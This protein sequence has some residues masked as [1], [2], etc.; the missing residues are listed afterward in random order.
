MRSE[1]RDTRYETRTGPIVLVQAP[2]IPLYG[3]TSVRPRLPHLTCAD[4]VLGCVQP[5]VM[6][7]VGFCVF[8]LSRSYGVCPSRPPWGRLKL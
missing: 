2:R 6:V 4:R 3:R 8:C 7:Y 1:T 5:T